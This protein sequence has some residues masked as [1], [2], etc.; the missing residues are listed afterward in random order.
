[1]SAF[2]LTF[3]GTSACDFG[4]RLQTESPRG[5]FCGEGHYRSRRRIAR[6]RKGCREEYLPR[7][8]KTE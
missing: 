7:N 8:E 3:L 5:L 6:A 2:Q 4:E 1:M